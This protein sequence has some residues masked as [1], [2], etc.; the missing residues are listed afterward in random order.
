MQKIDTVRYYLLLEYHIVLTLIFSYT[1][2][3]LSC[4]ESY[5][6]SYSTIILYSRDHKGLGVVL[7]PSDK[8]N[9]IMAKAMGST[10]G[11]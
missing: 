10:V 9:L 4:T 11:I 1:C 6:T 5:S 8:C 3:N 7:M 2:I